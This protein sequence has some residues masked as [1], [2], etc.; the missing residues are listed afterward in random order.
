M[1]SLSFLR[2]CAR[3]TEQKETGAVRPLYKCDADMSVDKLRLTLYGFA[4]VGIVDR[5]QRCRKPLREAAVIRHCSP[6]D[7]P[8]STLD[9]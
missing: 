9:S 3:T 6:R 2:Y 5:K 1:G 7:L 8:I 4:T